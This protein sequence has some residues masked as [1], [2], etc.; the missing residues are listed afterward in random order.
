M[1]PQREREI[2]ALEYVYDNDQG[3]LLEPAGLRGLRELLGETEALH[4]GIALKQA[5]LITD[6]GRL[7]GG[8]HITARG[9]QAVEEMRARRT[10]RGHR[11]TACRNDLLKWVDANTKAD[12]PGTRIARENFNGSL[13]LEPFSDEEVLA[14]A[15]YLEDNGFIRSISALGGRH[16]LMWVTARGQEA[17]DAGGVENFVWRDY[18]VGQVT[19]YNFGGTGNTIAAA[20]GA[21]SQATATTSSFDPAKALEF[22]RAVRDALPVLNLPEE[23]IVALAEIE[24]DGDPGLRQR[25]TARLYQ[26]VSDTGASGLGQVLAVLGAGALGISM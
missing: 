9:R 5:G 17:V 13:D 7:S 19:N 18:P 23:A 15:D 21:H 11:R 8:Y 10:D 4:T 24:Q 25:A 12:D 22:A 16:I 2:R 3:M 26:F 14:A 6:D 20:I 1:T